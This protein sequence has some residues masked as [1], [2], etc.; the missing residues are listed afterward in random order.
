MNNFRDEVKKRPLAAI[1]NNPI[2]AAATS[3]PDN[4]AGG[5]TPKSQAA[6]RRRIL[7]S[8]ADDDDDD[9]SDNDNSGTLVDRYF[10]TFKKPVPKKGSH[11]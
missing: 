3:T 10:E 4:R 8:F 2:E 6:K 5:G 11:R 1:E 7:K 9:E